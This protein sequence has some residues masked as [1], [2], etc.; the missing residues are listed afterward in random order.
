MSLQNHIFFQPFNYS[1]CIFIKLHSLTFLISFSFDFCIIVSFIF[2][3]VYWPSTATEEISAL[4][5]LF[6]MWFFGTVSWISAAEKPP[7]EL[8]VEVMW[9]NEILLSGHNK[10]ANK[11]NLSK[12]ESHFMH[13]CS[14]WRRRKWCIWEVDAQ[15]TWES[16]PKMG[17]PYELQQSF[18]HLIIFNILSRSKI[19]PCTISI[20]MLKLFPVLARFFCS[21]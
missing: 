13:L 21:G 14:I 8:F 16:C 4:S 18:F 7:D 5:S 10:R 17:M 9:P 11:Q 19:H 12:S 2:E 15:M 1:I 6:C 20:C 3:T